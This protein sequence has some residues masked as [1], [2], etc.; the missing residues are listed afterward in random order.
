MPE[1]VYQA[2]SEVAHELPNLRKQ[3][4][5]LEG[6]WRNL[7]ALAQIGQVVNSSLDLDMVLQIVMDTIIRL[8][9][10]ERGFLM[11]GQDGTDELEVRVARNW[12]QEIARPARNSQSAGPSCKRVAIDGQPMLTTNAQDDPRFEGQQSMVAYN[13]RS[14]LCVPLQVKAR[15]DRRDLRR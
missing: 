13:L 5:A 3:V 4:A 14:I 7:R 2:V 8:T 15:A 1:K 9:G 11:L 6:E 12:E 10:A